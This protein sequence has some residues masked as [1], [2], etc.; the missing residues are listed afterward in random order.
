MNREQYTTFLGVRRSNNV[1]IGLARF[2]RK[3]M[4]SKDI[5]S[6]ISELNEEQM[7]V[8]DLITYQSLLPTPE[9]KKEITRHIKKPPALPFGPAESFMIETLNYPDL[10]IQVLAFLFKKQLQS[11]I[12]EIESKVNQMIDLSSN[13]KSSLQFKKLL[14]LVLELGNLTNYQYGANNASYRP[15][16]GK[17]ARAIGFRIDGLARLRD[18]KSADG[19]WSLMT[20]LVEMIHKNYPEILSLADDFPE[21]KLVSTYDIRELYSQLQAMEA[22]QEELQNY[23]FESNSFQT[24]LTN[25]I[26]NTSQP[27]ILNLR[28]RFEVYSKSWKDLIRYF[29]EDPEEYIDIFEELSNSENG[30]RKQPGYLFVSLN[31]FFQPFKDAVGKFKEDEERALQKAQREANRS[32]SNSQKSLNSL[33]LQDSSFSVLMESSENNSNLPSPNNN[34]ELQMN[35]QK[36]SQPGMNVFEKRKSKVLEKITHQYN[37]YSTE[38][39][40]E[41]DSHSRNET[42]SILEA[43]AYGGQ[44]THEKEDPHLVLKRYSRNLQFTSTEALKMAT[45]VGSTDDL[46]KENG[47]CEKCQLDKQSCEC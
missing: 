12:S 30:S 3:G 21:L 13:L 18:V 36:E 29:G 41:L 2:T 45:T 27:M 43:A 44:I 34:H 38:N 28:Q 16:M 19:K 42:E 14:K 39:Q 33:E 32:K 5:I 8:D 15:W 1:A 17:E 22:T 23:D 46:G 31:L 35:T 24:R 7:H 10:H 4:S 37:V 25:Y 9:E 20:F 47:I 26:Q 40:V 6:I 11:E